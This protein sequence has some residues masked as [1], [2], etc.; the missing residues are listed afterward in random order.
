MRLKDIAEAKLPKVNFTKQKPT[1]QEKVAIAKQLASYI[2]A[3]LTKKKALELIDDMFTDAV[4]YAGFKAGKNQEVSDILTQALNPLK[5][6]VLDYI[7]KPTPKNIYDIIEMI[8]VFK[9]LGI[10]WPELDM[11]TKELA[12]SIKNELFQFYLEDYI[13]MGYASE[14]K[15]H[16][17]ELKRLGLNPK[18]FIAYAK[19]NPNAFIKV[20]SQYVKKGEYNNLNDA[21]GKIKELQ[22]DTADVQNVLLK[23]KKKI[24]QD[25]LLSFA[26]DTS[27]YTQISNIISMLGVSWPELTDPKALKS[28]LESNKTIIVKKILTDIKNS[29]GDTFFSTSIDHLPKVFKKLKKLGINWPEIAIIEKGL[30]SKKQ[31]TRP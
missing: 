4:D 29:F 23:N 9:S 12:R 2:T 14:I 17:D 31:G 7:N 21:A 15:L 22:V 3:A 28:E 8:R 1:E 13:Y 10:A 26:E 24:I 5:P 20:F 27:A 16:A 6:Q 19:N 30:F 18:E 25:A 11:D